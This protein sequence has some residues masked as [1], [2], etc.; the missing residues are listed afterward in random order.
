MKAKNKIR[1]ATACGVK[2]TPMDT[3]RKIS[4]RG[5]AAGKGDAKRRSREHY[6]EI[7]RKRWDAYRARKA[8]EAQQP[9][10]QTNETL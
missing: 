8:A 9:E 3:H 2:P 4:S 5:G 6:I 1:T 10:T 7:N